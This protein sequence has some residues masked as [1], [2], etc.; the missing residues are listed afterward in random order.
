MLLELIDHFDAELLL[1]FSWGGAA[2][3]VALAHRPRRIEKAVISSF[4]PVIN[5]A[6]LDYLER[7]GDYLGSSR[8]STGVGE[9]VNSTIGKHLPS[10]FKRYN[11]KHVSSLD[12]HEYAQMH[13]HI[14]H[15]LD[16]SNHPQMKAAKRINVPVL[17]M[18]GAWDEYTSAADARHF[19]HYI[20]D[21]HFSTIQDAGH[22]L[23][24]ENKAACLA[25]KS[26]LQGFLTPA[27]EPRRVHYRANQSQQAFAV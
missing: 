10:L 16:A 9:L 7:G 22:F 4:S 15:V 23:D 5:D 2:A 6:L 18:N 19:A 1:S 17:F 21:C 12:L 24:M 20:R 14:D 3:L 25:S 13:H 27:P 8:S 26:A 11:H